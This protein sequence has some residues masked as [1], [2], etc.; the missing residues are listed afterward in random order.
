M[1]PPCEQE[2]VR[3]LYRRPGLAEALREP[4]EA[5]AAGPPDLAAL[6]TW[7]WPLTAAPQRHV[8]ADA[9]WLAAHLAPLAL[10]ADDM[11]PG[12]GACMCLLKVA[13]Q[14]MLSLCCDISDPC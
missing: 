2:L 11:E 3:A 6:L 1:S 12:A 9:Q 5:R 7:L 13:K 4:D 8:R 14:N 10:A